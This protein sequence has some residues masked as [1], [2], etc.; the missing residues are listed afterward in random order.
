MK[1]LLLK[2]MRK[3]CP[4]IKIKINIKIKIKI[5]M[6]MIMFRRTMMRKGIIQNNNFIAKKHIS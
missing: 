6:E 5:N 3:Q 1:N 4:K 2:E